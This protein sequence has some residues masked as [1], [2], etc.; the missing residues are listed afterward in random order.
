MPAALVRCIRPNTR[1]DA[2][3]TYQGPLP[4]SRSR[5]IRTPR[6]MTSSKMP[7]ARPH[8]TA[9]GRALGVTN[10]DPD[11]RW[12]TTFQATMPRTG[13]ASP[14][15]EKD[16]S[17]CRHERNTTMRTSPT[18]IRPMAPATST[19]IAP[20]PMTTVGMAAAKSAT[21]KRMTPKAMGCLVEKDFTVLLLRI[22]Y[23]LGN[24][25]T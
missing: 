18:R 19:E 20:P 1:A 9:P 5:S 7:G 23:G 24:A 14:S 8:R 13:R 11:M 6:K 15:A 17:Q 10:P 4:L 16:L 22:A 2:T 3:S 21:K 12:Y 25:S